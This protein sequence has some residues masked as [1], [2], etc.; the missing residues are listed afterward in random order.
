VCHFVFF[1]N[2]TGRK[3]N[4]AEKP[5]P[6]AEPPEPVLPGSLATSSVSLAV[7]KRGA[8]IQDI[9]LYKYIAA[10]KYRK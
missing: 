3:S 2:I 1:C 10:L 7:A 4:T 6:S 9:P 5:T 8:K